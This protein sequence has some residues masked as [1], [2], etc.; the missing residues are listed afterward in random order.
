MFVRRGRAIPGVFARLQCIIIDELHSFCGNARGKQ[1]QCLL[2]RL[3]QAIGRRIPRIALSATVGEMAL[4]AEFLRP[5]N[6]DTVQLIRSQFPDRIVEISVC[7]YRPAER[8]RII[9]KLWDL[10]GSNNLIFAN[11]KADVEHY[12]DLLRRRSEVSGVGNEFVPHHAGISKRLRENTEFALKLQSQPIT[13]VCTSTLE[14]GIDVGEIKRVAQ[15]GPPR[16][17]ASLLQRLGRSGRRGNAAV[18]TVHIVE[19]TI[20]PATAVSGA[21]HED[22]VQTIAI[23]DL[24]LS[25]WCEPPRLSGLHLSTLLQQILSTIAQRMPVKA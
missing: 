1:L 20:T 21:F 11:S 15:I 2:A 6:G 9:D 25:G 8:T 24:G 5:R 7:G 23:V 13:A 19:P 22:L 14:L 12:T 3:E 10:R 4:A 18:L 16:S 17:V